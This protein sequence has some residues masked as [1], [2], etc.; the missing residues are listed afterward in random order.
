MSLNT[1]TENF[2]VS[3]PTWLIELLD[4]HCRKHG[5]TRSGFITV[6]VRRRIM[7]EIESKWLWE[8][9][10]KKMTEESC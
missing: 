9:A 8:Y 1:E 6:A 7:S 3:M 4:D 5:F 10:Y 2:S